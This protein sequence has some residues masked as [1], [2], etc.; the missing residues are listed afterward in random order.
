VS[1]ETAAALERA[2]RR[3]DALD[4]YPQPVRLDGVRVVVAPWL[5]RLPRMR[6]YAAYA[7]WRTILLRRPLG[8]GTSDDVLTH[9]LC[10]IWQG[11]QRRW[12]MLLAYATTRY[13]DNPFEVEARRAV[14]LTR[15][16]GLAGRPAILPG[17]APID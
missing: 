7:L 13:R 6:R 3:L 4:L 1:P 17:R 5:F 14:A 8:A 10:H 11:Q 12:R 16:R 9:E 2:R 15:R